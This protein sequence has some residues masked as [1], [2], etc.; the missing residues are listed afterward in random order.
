MNIAMRI[1]YIASVVALF[2]GLLLMVGCQGL[3][4]A[5]TRQFQSSEGVPKQL[6]EHQVIVVLT[7]AAKAEREKTVAALAQT[8]KL[9]KV[10][11]FPLRSID[12]Q[13]AVF[14]VPPRRSLTELIARI[15][16]DPRVESAQPNH[17]FHGQ[18]RQYNDQYA[19]QQY[20][21][22]AVRASLA[23][24]S[25]TGKGVKV[26]VIDTG[27]DTTHP[28]LQGRI[29]GTANFV[30]GGKASFDRDRHGTAVA[31]IIAARADNDI[32][33]FGVA[34]EAELIAL[35]ACWHGSGDSRQALCSSWTIA[36]AVDFALRQG[37]KVLN[38]SLAGPPDRLLQR[39]L[40]RA[41]SQGIVVVA[42]TFQQQP[43]IG[44]PASMDRVIA[45]VSSDHQG[46]ARLTAP[47]ADNTVLAA[48]GVDILTTAPQQTYD[49]L[50][51][52][53]LA[54]AHVSGI[55]AL[56]LEHHPSL[57]PTRVRSVLQTT[58]R[59]IETPGGQPE[60]RLGIVDAC[61][62]L[63]QLQAVPTCPAS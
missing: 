5:R 23:H 58:A 10:G 12:A 7:A 46:R 1:T 24:T 27:V 56:L 53:S 39:L 38:F 32:G 14:Q 15:E 43:N 61:A 36:R 44:F 37:I 52:S 45:V 42:A 41:L 18:R 54:A 55:A 51:G 48:P 8:Y 2:S 62:A 6:L 19:E 49:F 34:P 4:Q 17:F 30:T 60:T 20:G 13:C 9:S 40:T 50:S 25:A 57:T 26:A 35:K 47:S 28:D 11:T 29:V 3:D 63:K 21:A 16:A 33:I 22:H 59:P 31:G